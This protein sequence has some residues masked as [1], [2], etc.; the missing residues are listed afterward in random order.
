MWEKKHSLLRRQSRGGIGNRKVKM[1][2]MVSKGKCHLNHHFLSY[3]GFLFLFLYF[4]LP[5]SFFC[6]ILFPFLPLPLSLSP[7]SSFYL[8][9]NVWCGTNI[10]RI[11]VINIFL[12]ALVISKDVTLLI[13]LTPCSCQ[14][15]CFSQMM[16]PLSAC[17]HG[18]QQ[19]RQELV[20]LHWAVPESRPGT[21]TFQIARAIATVFLLSA[22]TEM[23]NW[24]TSALPSPSC[25][26]LNT[27]DMAIII[28]NCLQ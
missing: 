4:P 10:L 5:S 18:S 15:L 3:L 24:V 27:S 8:S 12:S 1:G 17:F 9:P 28:T 21:T 20:W 13:D 16:I 2:M 22:M 26:Y 14:V 6:F 23:L 11:M 7:P 25:Y 19:S